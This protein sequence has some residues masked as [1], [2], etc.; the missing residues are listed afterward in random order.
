LQT[1]ARASDD[2][3]LMERL[4]AQTDS[5]LK[6]MPLSTVLTNTRCFPPE[7]M[8]LITTG[9]ASGNV[10]EMLRKIGEYMR[11]DLHTRMKTLPMKA[12]VVLY[13]IVAPIVAYVVGTTFQWYFD[14]MFKAAGGD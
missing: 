5:F 2:Y 12:Q 11:D 9:E 13:L 10:P 6:G 14:T 3:R 8:Y 7:A 1:A 4:S